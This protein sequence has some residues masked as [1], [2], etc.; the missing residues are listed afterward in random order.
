MN[1]TQ[2]PPSDPGKDPS[3]SSIPVPLAAQAQDQA[4]GVEERK[5]SMPVAAAG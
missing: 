4:Q 1:G 5:G 3:A 2:Q